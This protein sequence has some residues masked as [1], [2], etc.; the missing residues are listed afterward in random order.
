M[1]CHFY[2][3]NHGFKFQDSVCNYCHD[4]M[5]HCVNISNIAI[6]AVKGTDYCCITNEIKKFNALIY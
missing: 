6:I 3:F 1:I 4:L 5:T 2:F